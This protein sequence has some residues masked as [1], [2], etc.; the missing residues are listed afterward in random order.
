VPLVHRIAVI[1]GSAAFVGGLFWGGTQPQEAES[2]H[3]AASRFHLAVTA[4]ALAIISAFHGLERT[5]LIAA[6]ELAA[7]AYLILLAPGIQITYLL[8][9]SGTSSLE[10][11]GWGIAI[12]MGAVPVALMWLIWLGIAPTREVVL[13]LA[14]G[15]VVVGA[16][17]VHL[18]PDRFN[19]QNS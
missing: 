1:I 5:P 15:L 2:S 13:G 4:L 7:G 12:S 6:V 11:L 18:L 8:I 19:L 16:C 14:T 17:L 3:R 9:G 10:R